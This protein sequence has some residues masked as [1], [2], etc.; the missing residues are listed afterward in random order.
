MT[1]LLSQSQLIEQGG[2]SQSALLPQEFWSRQHEQRHHFQDSPSAVSWN[3]ISMIRHKIQ[4]FD[5]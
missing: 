1:T 5:V 2:D 4:K 3:K